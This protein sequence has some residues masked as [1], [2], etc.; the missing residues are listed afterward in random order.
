MLRRIILLSKQLISI[1]STKENPKKLEKVLDTAKK[2]LQEFMIEE[3]EKDDIRSIIVYNSKTRPK[4][5]KLVLN[6][7]LDVVPAKENQYK[8]YEKVGKLYGRGAY[9]MK[10]AAAV[11]I[12]VFKEL[13]E[14]VKYPLA[15][16]LVTDEEVGGFKGTKHQIDQDVRADFV[17]AGENTDLTIINR[18]KGIVWAKITTKGS[19]AHGAYPWLGKNA[20]VKMNMVINQLLK[21]YPIPPNEVWRTTVNISTIET[22]NKTN[23]KVPDDCTLTL[24]VRYVPEDKEKII[25]CLKK[26]ENGDTKVEIM[27]QESC[28]FTNK[29][30]LHIKLLNSSLKKV[31]GKESFI[32]PHHGGSDIRHYNK[33][34]CNGIE[35]GPKG[36]GHHTDNEWVDIKSLEDYYNILKDFLLKI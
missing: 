16:Q 20:V 30:N 17:I 3:F 4:K 25:S 5:F 6:A 2:E 26:F 36:A 8:P 35:F 31:M 1:P 9:D 14:K 28:Y 19:T 32:L 7:H 22:S 29:N 34:G 10:A 23:N 18:A 11:E 33:V 15:L 24:D 21:D 13:A 12:L 27:L